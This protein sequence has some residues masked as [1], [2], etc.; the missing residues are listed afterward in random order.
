MC[1]CINI[2]VMEINLL[3]HVVSKWDGLRV[4]LLPENFAKIWLQLA[5]T[6]LTT[7]RRAQFQLEALI[8]NDIITSKAT[9]YTELTSSEISI[10]LE[11]VACHEHCAS[12]KSRRLSIVRLKVSICTLQWPYSLALSS[13]DNLWYDTQ[14]HFAQYYG[15]CNFAELLWTEA[16]QH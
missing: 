14:R 6:L 11:I 12:E 5:I 8:C 4:L 16:R 10:Y 1:D 15:D 3:Y 9:E 7:T 13:G 2:K